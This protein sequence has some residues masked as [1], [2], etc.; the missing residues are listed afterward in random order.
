MGVH[1]RCQPVTVALGT[2]C[3]RLALNNSISYSPKVIVQARLGE[4]GA[5]AGR[6]CWRDAGILTV[7]ATVTV[8]VCAATVGGAMPGPLMQ[9]HIHYPTETSILSDLA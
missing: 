1:S 4:S 8:P 5:E 3:A 6:L 9:A 7:G 2:D